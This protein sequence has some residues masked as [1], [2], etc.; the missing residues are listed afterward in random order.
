LQFINI[1]LNVACMRLPESI[2][3]AP[4][5]ATIDVADA[6]GCRVRN[7]NDIDS[8]FAEAEARE[9]EEGNRFFKRL[10]REYV[11]NESMSFVDTYKLVQEK[12]Y[13]DTIT[14][15]K[16]NTLN[17]AYG[18]IS[19]R[20]VMP[21]HYGMEISGEALVDRIQAHLLRQLKN[22]DFKKDKPLLIW[23]APGIGKT[24]IIKQA[25][26]L[27]AGEYDR[28]GE[29]INL[30]MVTL[31]C[32]GIRRDDMSLPASAQNILGNEMAAYIPQTWLPVY[33]PNKLSNAELKMTDDFYNASAHKIF[34][35]ANLDKKR[36]E[37]EKDGEKVTRNTFEIDS[38][39]SES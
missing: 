9:S 12:Y 26:K 21:D 37:D 18:T 11:A 10:M 32:A 34:K 27:L 29:L 38:A 4:S 15:K 25:A 39:S 24:T 2:K 28:D 35:V 7:N 14:G 3:F 31:A 17:E 19:L 33:D 1:P 5:R 23:G 13:R 6:M 8:I 22:M 20:N 30:D 36:F 16:A